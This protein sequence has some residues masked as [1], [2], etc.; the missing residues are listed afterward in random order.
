MREREER[1]VSC[2]G[3]FRPPPP[4][5]PCPAARTPGARAAT[6]QVIRGWRGGGAR[7]VSLW[8]RGV[9]LDAGDVCCVHTMFAVSSTQRCTRAVQRGHMREVRPQPSAARPLSP[10]R[11]YATP[12]EQR[13]QCGAQREELWAQREKR[14][15]GG[16]ERTW[17]MKA[18][19]SGLRA[20]AAA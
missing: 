5:A 3:S 11:W 12:C 18:A 6:D 4:R 14:G 13:T 7:Q 10:M 20:L 15:Q 16:R 9:Q 17:L 19:A 8:D 2:G 1:P